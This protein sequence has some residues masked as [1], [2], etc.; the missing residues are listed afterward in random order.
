M[1]ASAH[2]LIRRAALSVLTLW[3]ITII[4]FAL[5]RIAPGDAVLAAMA[6]SPGEMSLS[7]AAMEERRADLGL[8]RSYAAQYLSWLGGLLRLDPGASI[9]TG[10]PIGPEVAPRIA[11]TIQLAL[12]SALTA[13]LAGTLA[14]VAAAA[15]K[16]GPFDAA[17]RTLALAA[18]SAPAF[19]LG[20]ILVLALAAWANI[21]VA[22]G[23]RPIWDDPAA[24]LTR[25]MPAATVLAARPAALVF[26]IVRIS[27]VEILESDFI[28]TARA[29]GLTETR[30]LW[31]HAFPAA[32]LPGITALGVQTVFLLSGAVVIEQVFGL[33][34]LGR[35]LTEGVLTRDYP[36]VQFLVLLFGFFALLTNFTM[37]AVY[38]RLDPRVRLAA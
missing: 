23:Y 24:N 19:W 12:L 35:S 10:L 17:A 25:I 20:L 27:T 9:A 37:D 29:R 36:L 32:A 21:F 38:T 22:A 31:G 13:G 11:V 2:Y 16:D 5:L 15:W 4:A 34:G 26:R 8:D 28:R 6:R 3:L 18:L 14:G 7:A 33:P 30:I 1:S